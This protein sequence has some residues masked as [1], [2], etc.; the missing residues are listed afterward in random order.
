LDKIILLNLNSIEKNRF[1]LIVWVPKRSYSSSVDSLL[2]SQRRALIFIIRPSTLLCFAL[3]AFAFVDAS[4]FLFIHSVSSYNSADNLFTPG[5]L[6]LWL[7]L[8]FFGPARFGPD[9]PSCRV[10]RW[11]LRWRSAVRVIERERERYRE[12][13]LVGGTTIATT[14]GFVVPLPL[15]LIPSHCLICNC[16]TIF[17]IVSAAKS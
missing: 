13:I 10:D 12:R 8:F 5:A 14:T 4:P 17:V 16:I 3:L 6:G 9:S 2:D 1:K 11:R 7:R 15:F